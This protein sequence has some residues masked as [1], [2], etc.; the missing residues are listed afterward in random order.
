MS[1]EV[2]YSTPTI[3]DLYGGEWGEMFESFTY[4]YDDENSRFI[5]RR[6]Y[7][8][9]NSWKPNT[10]YKKTEEEEIQLSDL[11]E[12]ALMEFKL[13]TSGSSSTR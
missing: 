4:L 1:L 7:G 3:Y 10:S 11:H 12:E 8:R 13:A 9:H 6:E 5:E 2:L